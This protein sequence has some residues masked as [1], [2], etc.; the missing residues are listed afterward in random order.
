MN[1]VAIAFSS[2]DRCELS[3]R[4]IEPLL[5]PDKFDLFWIDGSNT[6]EGMALP[7]YY[8][9][10]DVHRG[11]RGGSGAA[12]VYALTT[13]L[14]HPNNYAY[15][16]LV[17]N[18][19]L[20]GPDWFNPTMELFSHGWGDG[21][22]KV[23]AASGRC[24]EDRILVQREGYA[25]MHNLGAGMVVFDREAAG[26]VLDYYRTQFTTENR[27]IFSVLAGT[28]IGRY[29]AFRGGEHM[30]VADW[31]WDALLA[32]RGMCSLALTP[33]PVEMIGQVPPLAE[34]G[35]T[36]VTEPSS[37]DSNPEG[38]FERYRDNLN[39]IRAGKL[40]MP[41]YR[42][43]QNNIFPH[44]IPLLG[45]SYSGDWHLKDAQ[46]FGPFAWKAGIFN[47]NTSQQ[48]IMEVPIF[49]PCEILVSGGESGSRVKV[50]DT[51]SG[52]SCDPDLMSEG[53]QGSILNLTIPGGMSYRTIRLTAL[54]PGA[55]FYGIKVMYSQPEHPRVKFDYSVLPPV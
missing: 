40:K 35:L 51:Y 44:Q 43:C 48:C 30:L 54:A 20:L 32:T 18:D 23:G 45:G 9:N 24:F 13:M 53:L 47:D 39:A 10:V 50:E 41:D 31:R 5:Q 2:K 28:D 15:V 42:F 33:S 36:L 11:I 8:S 7:T 26:L 46:G 38:V 25:V 49:G 37:P 19:V 6:E 21:F 22:K 52:F 55:I 27:A 34:Q 17:E 4:S 12:I 1:T 29:W 16:G 14:R 3:R